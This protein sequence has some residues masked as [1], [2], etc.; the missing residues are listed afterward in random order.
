MQSVLD[1]QQFIRLVA[2]IVDG[3]HL[4]L[5]RRDF[6]SAGFIAQDPGQ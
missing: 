3:V 5:P 2:S 4:H 6:A 1:Q